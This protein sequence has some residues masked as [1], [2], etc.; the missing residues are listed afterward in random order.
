VQRQNKRARNQKEKERKIRAKEDQEGLHG[1]WNLSPEKL[2]SHLD[3]L[4]NK[5]LIDYFSDIEKNSFKAVL[6]YYLNSG[7]GRFQQYK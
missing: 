2:F 6:L 3:S 5:Q 1:D 7:Y 4:D